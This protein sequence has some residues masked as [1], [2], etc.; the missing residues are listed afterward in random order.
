[1]CE[2]N[3]IGCSLEILL[4]EDLYNYFSGIHHIMLVAEIVEFEKSERA[5]FIFG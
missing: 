3:L 2:D 4:F 1:M 5:K